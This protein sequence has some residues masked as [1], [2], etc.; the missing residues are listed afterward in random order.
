MGPDMVARDRDRRRLVLELLA[1]G[2]VVD[3]PDHYHAAMVFQHG[4]SQEWSASKIVRSSAFIGR[5]ADAAPATSRLRATTVVPAA[6]PEAFVR[7]AGPV[8]A[9]PPASRGRGSGAGSHRR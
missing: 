4:G 1:A 7:S 3:G 9:A 5:S 8:C 2:E 6:C